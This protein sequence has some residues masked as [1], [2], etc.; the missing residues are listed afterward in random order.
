M[1]PSERALNYFVFLVSSAFFFFQFFAARGRLNFHFY[2][3]S[4]TDKSHRI[5]K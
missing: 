5:N 4:K 2:C 3:E 1:G